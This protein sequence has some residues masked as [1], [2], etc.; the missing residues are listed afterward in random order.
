MKIDVVIVT[1]NRL[2]KLKKTLDCYARQTR[3]FRNLVVVNNH[4]TDGTTEYL[5]TWQ[6][7]T[8]PYGKYVINTDDNLGGAGGFYLGEKKA[9]TMDPDWLFIADDDAYPE[10]DMMEQFYRFSEQHPVDSYSAVC[11]VVMK[12]DGDFDL[13][14]RSRYTV[15]PSNHLIWES[16][17]LEDY[18]KPFFKVDFLSYVGPFINSKALKKV[19]Y[20]DPEFFIYNDDSEHSLRL[21]KY[22]EIICVP[23]IRIVHDVK[24]VSQF[25]GQVAEQ[26]ASVSWGD[27][28]SNRN[29]MVMLKRHLPKVAWKRFKSALKARLKGLNTTPYD[30]LKWIAIRDAWL[31]RMGKHPVYKPGWS[32]N[33]K[34]SK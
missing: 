4:S 32:I 25:K 26:T 1:F 6:Q 18:Q 8:T 12:P 16:V 10:P 7:S 19:G 3:P 28:Y 15:T 9:M 5:E 17:P 31:H 21:N 29:E 30:K 20:I 22:G 23:S 11:A 33:E 34:K 27:Y 14:H 24:T 2:E 13:C